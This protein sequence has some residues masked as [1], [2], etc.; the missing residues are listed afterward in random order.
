MNEPLK[1][2]VLDRTDTQDFEQLMSLLKKFT[3][4]TYIRNKPE[5]SELRGKKEDEVVN[6]AIQEYENQ[7]SL[8]I[9]T[10]E[11]IEQLKNDINSQISLAKESIDKKINR[12]TETRYYVMKD[13]DRIVSF[14]QAQLVKG[15]DNGR[16]EGWRT[17]A[18]ADPD[19]RGS[20]QAIDSRGVMHQGRYSEIIYDDIGQWFED[21]GVNYER[22]CTGANM[23][24]NLKAYI[25][26]K[27]FLP[28]D[29]NDKNIFLEKFKE[30]RVDKKTLRKISDLYSQH[31][32]RTEYKRKDEI[33][34]EIM[35]I[36]EFEGLTEEQKRGL[37][38]C[39][40]KEGEKGKNGFEDCMEDDRTISSRVQST[41]QDTKDNVLGDANIAGAREEKLDY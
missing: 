9:L 8:S 19:Y 20:G 28:F 30:H 39:F 3:I 16:I 14:Q 23:L 38:Q 2:S 29:K 32:E 5:F 15:R 4:D 35:S 25:V 26:I 27:G 13:G 12:N 6:T 37:V 21:N 7:I 31:R 41:T 1:I 22:T 34:E 33:L 24:K 17:F 40:L 36:P 10:Q 11:D 18:Y